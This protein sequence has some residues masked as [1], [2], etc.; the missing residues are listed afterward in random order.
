MFGYRYAS[1]QDTPAVAVTPVVQSDLVARDSR[2]SLTTSV[3]NNLT[4]QPSGALRNTDVAGPGKFAVE[5]LAANAGIPST[6]GVGWNYGA[7]STAGVRPL[8]D[9]RKSSST[10]VT[11]HTASQPNVAVPSTARVRSNAE[12]PSTAGVG[13]NARASSTAG[14]RPLNDARK[15]SSTDVTSHTASHPNVGVPSTAGVWSNAEVP[16]KAGVR[17]PIEARVSSSANISSR[18]NSHTNVAVPSMARVQ[19]NAGEPTTVRVRSNTEVSSTAG[20]QSL[21]EARITPNTEDVASLAASYPNVGFTVADDTKVEQTEVKLPS[22]DDHPVSNHPVSLSSSTP[23]WKVVEVRRETSRDSLVIGRRNSRQDLLANVGTPTAP[24]RLPNT[25]QTPNGND[26]GS[27]FNDEMY[28]VSARQYHNANSQSASLAECLLNTIQPRNVPLL[29]RTDSLQSLNSSKSSGQKTDKSAQLLTSAE[30]L[31]FLKTL[32]TLGKKTDRSAQL[33]HSSDNFQSLK[34]SKPSGQMIAVDR[35]DESEERGTVSSMPSMRKNSVVIDRVERPQPEIELWLDDDNNID[36]G[37]EEDPFTSCVDWGDEQDQFPKELDDLDIDDDDD[38]DDDNVDND[39]GNDEDNDDDNDDDDND[40][41]NAESLMS[42]LRQL[43]SVLDEQ[44]PPSPPV[45]FPSPPSS[46]QSSEQPIPEERTKFVSRLPKPTTSEERTKLDSMCPKPSPSQERTKLVSRSPKPSPSQ[47]RTKNSSRSPKVV[48]RPSSTLPQ[49]TAGRSGCGGKNDKPT[50]SKQPPP[51]EERTKNASRSQHITPSPSSNRLGRD[52][53]KCDQPTI[54]AAAKPS[55]TA[56][57]WNRPSPSND[58]DDDDDV[59]DDDNDDDT[60]AIADH[61]STVSGTSNGPQRDDRL[62]AGGSI[63]SEAEAKP[64]ARGS[65]HTGKFI[66][67]QQ[68]SSTWATRGKP[69][70][71]TR[72]SRSTLRPTAERTDLLSRETVSP[73]VQPHNLSNPAFSDHMSRLQEHASDD[74]SLPAVRPLDSRQRDGRSLN[75]ER[76][77]AD[78]GGQQTMEDIED[79]YVEAMWLDA[80]GRVSGQASSVQWRQEL[81]SIIDSMRH[82]L[83]TQDGIRSRSNTRLNVLNSD[84]AE[85]S[86]KFTQAKTRQRRKR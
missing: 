7:S 42:R 33:L 17:S 26:A 50:A 6:A 57:S 2:Q 74:A 14:V 79:V 38:D 47:D 63:G 16:S 3:D 27:N 48:P 77:R 10:D 4:S 64:A 81:T 85:G 22:R 61:S 40:D 32:K 58:D 24:P 19:S 12:V 34:I 45:G 65:S 56:F 39:D 76:R 18:T 8:I 80:E 71:P 13:L 69:G 54:S 1:G 60:P 66:K 52:R 36:W 44:R 62:S 41:V 15:S 11:S 35:G 28:L 25:Q 20:V 53:T 43:S 9:T 73:A 75:V 49:T 86:R 72:Q 5:E 78:G 37:D 55:G 82:R 70:T 31:Q 59:D 67:Q 83:Q 51:K 68:G 29:D 84:D 23:D 46:V 21:T 30:S